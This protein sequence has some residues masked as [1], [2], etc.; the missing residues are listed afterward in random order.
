MMPLQLVND[1]GDI[2]VNTVAYG[3][4]SRAHAQQMKSQTG[5]M[6]VW[7]NRDAFSGSAPASLADWRS[8]RTQRQVR[9]TLSAEACA[10]DA[11]VDRGF[12]A[13]VFLPE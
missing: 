8:A 12:Y 6:I 1:S 9:P 2:D 3:D 5:A 7:A 4:S 13:S 11:A 10:A